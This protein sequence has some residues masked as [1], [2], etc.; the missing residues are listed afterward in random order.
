MQ[1]AGW[2]PEGGEAER[3]PITLPGGMSAVHV[4]RTALDLGATVDGP[5]VIT[6]PDATTYIPGE[7][8]ATVDAVGNL[9]VTPR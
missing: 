8:T 3:A 9:V 2:E 5:A 1:D 7:W 4:P 6:Q